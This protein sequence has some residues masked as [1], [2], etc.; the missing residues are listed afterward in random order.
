MKRRAPSGPGYDTGIPVNSCK[1]EE[2][3]KTTGG[4]LT[5]PLDVVVKECNRRAAELFSSILDKKDKADRIRNALNVIER[6]R[7]LFGL[8]DSIDKNIANKAYDIVLN[9]YKKAKS[10]FADT[11]IPRWSS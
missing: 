10:L 11:Q 7:F 4:S 1:D 9:D 5:T 6:F 8:P 2:E 3:T